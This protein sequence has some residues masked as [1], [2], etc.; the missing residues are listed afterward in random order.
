M[1][2]IEQLEFARRRENTG[3]SSVSGLDDAN[4][5]AK[6]SK[7]QSLTSKIPYATE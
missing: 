3:N 7:G 5:P 2:P 6:G 1:G 4:F